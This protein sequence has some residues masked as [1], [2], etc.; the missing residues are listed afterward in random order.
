[1]R[2][3]FHHHYY[4]MGDLE[5]ELEK[6]SHED[7]LEITQ[8]SLKRLIS[9]DSLLQDLPLDVTTDE[10]LSQVAVVQGQS[11]TVTIL[12]H[13]E[14]PLNVVIPQQGATVKDLKQAIQRCFSL[15]QQ[16]SKIKT[17][18]SWK[19]VWKAYVLQHEGMLLKK[20]TDLV[21]KYGV[22]N[23]SE[24]R[25]IKRLNDKGTRQP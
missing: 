12:R 14:S 15:K 18:I 23:R 7:L 13:S 8:S 21:S 17:K 24:L 4:W 19:Y 10:V 1:M 22:T 11:I 16:R 5:E 6:L 9:A 2:Y 20:N 25:F 3:F